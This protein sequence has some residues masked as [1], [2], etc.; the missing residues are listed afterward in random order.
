MFCTSFVGFI[1]QLAAEG[2]PSRGFEVSG[3][4]LA[5]LKAVSTSLE[6]SFH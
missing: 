4:I 3:C 6:F 1:G 5:D 2:C